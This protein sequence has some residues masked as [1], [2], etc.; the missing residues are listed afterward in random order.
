M[1]KPRERPLDIEELRMDDF[2]IYELITLYSLRK[3]EKNN[4]ELA[5]TKSG[6]I[7]PI[8]I[9]DIFRTHHISSGDIANAV[10][11]TIKEMKNRSDEFAIFQPWEDY[12][13]TV[14]IEHLL[15][16]EYKR[17]SNRERIYRIKKE[18]LAT[19][20]DLEHKGLIEDPIDSAN[21]NLITRLM[22]EQRNR[23]TKNTDKMDK[24][25][26]TIDRLKVIRQ[27]ASEK[28]EYKYA[29]LK[30]MLDLYDKFLSELATNA[31]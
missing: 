13:P 4:D 30:F 19:I 27:E 31:V 28:Q 8:L 15:G 9:A 18:Y 23:P 2:D 17:D 10:K 20:T 14:F 16:R 1:A 26:S 6:G 5:I 12:T 3:R 7:W 11:E 21:C 24:M 29:P 22:L 25:D